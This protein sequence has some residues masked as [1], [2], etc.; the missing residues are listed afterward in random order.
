MKH[1]VGADIV[2][3][4]TQARDLLREGRTAELA[5]RQVRRVAPPRVYGA[6]EIRA[7][8]RRV[9]VSQAVFASMLGVS[10]VLVQAWEQDKRKPS[11]LACR[12]L[13]VISGD[14]R[15]W[16]ALVKAA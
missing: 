5:I 15:P 3:S 9:N 2:A 8:R 11:A 10:T 16:K 1:S 4:L 6:N 14:L 12:L 7:L 13:D